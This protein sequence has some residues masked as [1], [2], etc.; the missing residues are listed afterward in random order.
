MTAEYGFSQRIPA[1]I[2]SK[3]QPH[4]KDLDRILNLET[5]PFHN[6]LHK[7]QVKRNAKLIAVE[8]NLNKQELEFL[9]KTTDLH[10]E[11]YKF[12]QAGILTP[13]EHHFG[14]AFIAMHT[15]HDEEIV[16]GILAHV[17]DVLP[18]DVPDWVVVL[19]DADRVDRLGWHGL[20]MEAYFMGLK[21]HIFD[22]PPPKQLTLDGKFIERE[23][24]RDTRYP[25]DAKYGVRIVNRCLDAVSELVWTDYEEQ[26]AEFCQ[27]H[28]FPFL[29]ENNLFQD[30][31]QRLHYWLNRF[32]GVDYYITPGN[33]FV[34]EGEKYDPDKIGWEI[35]QVMDITQA[36][37]AFKAF[38]TIK[39]VE[40]TYEYETLHNSELITQD[41]WRRKKFLREPIKK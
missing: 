10:D 21:H 20:A 32:Y 25:W 8:I 40:K 26:V 38:N 35:E 19:R 15:T 13:E 22:E 39:A 18:E 23:V 6:L 11:G 7:N 17:E 24:L 41:K 27:K 14:G 12:V 4:L 5:D 34:P 2:E 36:L 29:L 30:I 3:L 28:I 16:K 1:E 33:H 9:M 31:R 37:F